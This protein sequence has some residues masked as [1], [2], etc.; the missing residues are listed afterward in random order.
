MFTTSS[1]VVLSGVILDRGDESDWCFS[2]SGAEA[3]LG[4]SSVASLARI[5]S[6][7][8]DYRGPVETQPGQHD[9]VHLIMRE[10]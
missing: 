3:Q 8:V 4:S 2:V 9:V 6:D 5:L 7:I 10:P 1:G